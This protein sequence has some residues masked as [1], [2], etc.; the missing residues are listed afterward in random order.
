MEVWLV[1]LE[2]L[3]VDKDVEY[4]VVIEIDLVDVK[5]L[6][7]CVLNDLDDVCLLLSV[8]G[9]KIDEV[10]IGFCMINIGYF[11]VVGKLLDKVKGGILIC[12]WL[13]LLIKMDV[14]QLIEE[15]YYGIY[16][17]VGVCME[18]LGCL[19]CM[20]NQVCVQIGFIVVFIL[21]C[22]FLNCLGDVIDVFLV[23]VELVVVFL[24]FGKLLIVEE[25]MVYVKDID[26]MVVDVYCYLSFDQIVEFCEVVVN[27]KILVVQV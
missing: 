19:L 25:Y 3:E 5:E 13:V 17:K 26:S 12:L 1:K 10:F 7:F 9:C 2:L 6:V 18:M 11:C 8:Q 23:L 27:V 16:G 20:G 21:I 15:G 14:Y 4:V 22:N 24:I